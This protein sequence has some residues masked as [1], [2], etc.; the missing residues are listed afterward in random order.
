[1][2]AIFKALLAGSIVF[3]VANAMH[4]NPVV[5]QPVAKKVSERL[6]DEVDIRF[7]ICSAIATAS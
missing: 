7:E 4:T 3:M 6:F 1:M 2:K 5:E